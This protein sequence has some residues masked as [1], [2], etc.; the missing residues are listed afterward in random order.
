[1]LRY[2]KDIQ[3]SLLDVEIFNLNCTHKNSKPCIKPSLSLRNTQMVAS[4]KM[5]NSVW[6][7]QIKLEI[8]STTKSIFSLLETIWS[9]PGHV[10]FIGKVCCH[11]CTSVV[12]TL[13][14]TVRTWVLWMNVAGAQILWI[15]SGKSGA[16][17]LSAN[18]VF[19][20]QTHGACSPYILHHLLSS[21]S[22]SIS[23]LVCG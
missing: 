22:C 20:F 6:N 5:V 7:C 4:A 16:S 14:I 19:H 3:T 11:L 23:K 12:Y 13:F 18:I 1:M 9:P 15:K 17:T 2:S 10:C 8:F 21:S